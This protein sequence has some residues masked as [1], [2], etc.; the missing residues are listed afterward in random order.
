MKRLLFLF[1]PFTIVAQNQ[2]THH[3]TEK[4]L[5]FINALPQEQRQ[6]ALFSFDEMNRYEWHYVPPTMV[7]RTGISIKNIDSTAKVHFYDLLKSFLSPEGYTK[8]LDIMSFEYLL[9]ELEPQNSSRIPENYHV[10]IYG[11]P[12]IDTTWGWKYTGHHLALNFTVVNNKLAFAPF[13]FGSNPGEVKN[14][15]KKGKRILKMEED[16]GFDIVK[17]LSSAQKAKAIFQLKA[18]SDIVTTNSQE[19]NELEPTGILAKDMT[20]EQKITLNKLIMTYLSSMPANIAE[21]RMARIVKE[22]MEAIRF[23]WA[24]STEYGKPHYYRVQGKTFLIEFDNTQN[25]AN[26]IHTVW[27][28]FKGDYGRDL[29]KDHYLKAHKH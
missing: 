5:A 27:R 18:F 3:G 20:P 29:L 15:P 24:G 21:L 11:N 9:K 6:K 26:H 25:N 19:V 2:V 23:G 8:T 16:L 7:G 17:S 4:A 22:D 14:G 13:M 12:A 28:D 10:S 1:F